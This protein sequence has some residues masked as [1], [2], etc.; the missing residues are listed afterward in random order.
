M[1]TSTARLNGWTITHSTGARL[2][3]VRNP[4][5]VLVDAVEPVAWEWAPA[6]GGASR[7]TRKATGEDL[8]DAL[9]EYLAGAD[10]SAF[11]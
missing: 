8:F 3:E 7:A 11:A 4:Q 6:E 10:T 2:A 1:T 5:G 9:R